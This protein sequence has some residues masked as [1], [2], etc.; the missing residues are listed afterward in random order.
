MLTGAGVGRLVS[1]GCPV[2]RHDDRKSLVHARME[3]TGEKYT[4]AKRMLETRPRLML[5]LPEPVSGTDACPACSGSGFDGTA[6][7]MGEP[8]A[9]Q[10]LVCPVFCPRCHGCGRR[11]HRECSPHQHDDP[12]E[13]GFDPYDE[14]EAYGE[15][16]DGDEC[17][18]CGG[19]RWWVMQAFDTENVY[20]VRV[21]CGCSEQLLVVA[22]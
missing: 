4:V 22:P 15:E 21:P 18:S 20:A 1:K 8:E 2:T 12:E 11:K 14:R 7:E 10:V 13:F 5:P 3:R 9:N 17:Y 16:H 19:R 6:V